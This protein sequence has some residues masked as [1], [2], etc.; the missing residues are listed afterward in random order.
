MKRPAIPAVLRL[1]ISLAL[2]A[3]L[4]IWLD[5]AAIAAEIEDLAPGWALIA[6]LLTL[7][8]VA[9]SAWRWRFTARLLN[10]PLSRRAAFGDYYLTTFLNQL[11]PGGV[12]GDA[13][14][15]WRHANASGA[16]GPAIRSVIIER[17]SGQLVLWLIALLAL[18]TPIWHAPLSQ[19][20][21]A[22]LA[23]LTSIGALGWAALAIIA[24]GTAVTLA[25]L[26]RRPPHAFK[27]LS[28][29]LAS[30]LARD[31]ARTLTD[32][33]VWPRQLLASLLVV[34]SYI[35]VYVCAAR[36]IGA[37][38]PLTTL[39][40]LIPPV[41]MAMALPL[42]V[43]GWGLREGVAALV[44][45]SVGLPAEQGVAISMAYGVLVLVSSL[46]GGVFL[47]R[48]RHG[49][50]I[51]QAQVEQRVVAAG[52]ATRRRPARL[53]EGID[54]RQS[55]S[56]PPGTDQ[57]RRHQQVQTVQHV[58]ADEARH[59]HAA[60]FDQH[61]REPAFGQCDQDRPGRD[62]LRPGGQLETLDVA[63]DAR[64]TG[65]AMSDQVQRGRLVGLEDAMPGGEPTAR[66]EHH[67]ARVAPRDVTHAELR[68]VGGDGAGTDQHA[69]DQ[70]P[71]AMQMDA[72]L[73][74]V[75][76]VRGAAVGSDA[77]VETLAELGDRQPAAT[78][79]QRQQAVEQV[80][81][82]GGQVASAFPDAL[83]G[84]APR[85]PQ[86][87]RAAAQRRGGRD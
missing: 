46:P 30:G 69:V 75:D 8:Q 1:A 22:A 7:P 64:Q 16:R 59:G 74:A 72:T 78:R 62:A 49:S 37:D 47:L 61:P 45:A 51:E 33:R 67:P 28:Q 85:D 43:A 65:R 83:P 17:G 42:S 81:A 3:A 13:T 36:A 4:L 71:Q 60:A 70:R 84:T 73:E 77:S 2:L 63:A 25:W 26:Q 6:L 18:S 76:V 15:A 32:A 52:E 27:R 40:A 41:L 20:G 19:A 54:R 48:S 53:V 57:Q 82:G 29:A 58:G 68:V 55:Q 11:L 5:F 34:A 10:V 39:L 24:T 79:H 38:I 21:H 31:L 87:Q 50:D 44:W 14:R 80:A 86:G 12:M 66:V 56:G 9:V 35:A 23:A